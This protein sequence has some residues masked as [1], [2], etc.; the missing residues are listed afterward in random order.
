MYDFAS[1]APSKQ[2][3]GGKSS[4]HHEVGLDKVDGHNVAEWVANH[5]E[6]ITN[7]ELRELE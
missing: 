4:F 7:G 6:S 3:L 1:F 2:Q 5:C